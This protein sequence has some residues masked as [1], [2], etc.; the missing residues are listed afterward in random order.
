MPE[1]KGRTINIEEEVM[2]LIKEGKIKMRPRW[3]FVLG[4]FLGFLGLVGASLTALFLLNLLIFY[5]RAK[6]PF[7][8]WRIRFLLDNFPW[9]IPVLAGVFI[10][11]S[12]M[13]LKKYEFSYKKNFL[14]ITLAFVTALFVGA[15]LLD[16][17]GLNSF[18]LRRGPDHMKEFYKKVYPDFEKME[19]MMEKKHRRDN[20]MRFRKGHIKF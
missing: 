8:E 7:V 5:F 4:S 20:H 15:Y 19:E 11:L 9:W 13:F 2:K 10:F 14:L 17:F 18:M 12:I 1:K 6:G 3:Y 16:V